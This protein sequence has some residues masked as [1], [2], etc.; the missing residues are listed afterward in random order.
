ME[1]C[2]LCSC[3]CHM[4][5]YKDPIEFK[6]L[7]SFLHI[8]EKKTL[9]SEKQSDFPKFME[10]EWH[11]WNLESPFYN[12]ALSITLRYSLKVDFHKCG[13]LLTSVPPFK[14]KAGTFKTIRIIF[15][16]LNIYYNWTL[17][18]SKL[19]LI[20]FSIS[21]RNHT[22]T[23][24]CALRN[25]FWE[26]V[27]L[28]HYILPFQNILNHPVTL[29]APQCFSALGRGPIIQFDTNVFSENNNPS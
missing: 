26:L 22:Q 25:Y 13:H 6:H 19:Q 24:H 23:K 21:I 14:W 20:I 15:S 1:H 3:L 27:F 8:C 12:P 17:F 28:I 29:M 16:N 2:G 9:R 5:E 10:R 11:N 7:R 18:W 4:L